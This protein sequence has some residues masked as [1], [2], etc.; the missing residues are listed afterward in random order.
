MQHTST[1][2][3]WSGDGMAKERHSPHDST[4]RFV[5]YL[6]AHQPDLYAYINTLL[7]GDPSV[8]DVLQDTNLD[9]WARAGDFD[10]NRP[11]LPWGLGF[12]YQRVL[13][14]RKSRGRSRLVFSDQMAQLI[15]DIYL[16][17]TTPTDARL[18]ALQEC[19]GKLSRPQN[20]LIRLRYVDRV[21]VQSISQR[22]GRTA[23]QISAQLYR[24][25]RALAKCITR[26]LATE[27]Q[28]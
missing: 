8:S 27:S 3:A 13:A 12:A 11:F 24:I 18:T 17:D 21:S 7:A 25:R 16:S 26:A 6:T 5:E 2:S 9:L 28:Q 15:S 4:T 19:I 23:N 1:I 22:S 10:F 14:F 20:E